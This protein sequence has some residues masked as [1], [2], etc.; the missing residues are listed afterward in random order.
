MRACA[1]NVCMQCVHTGVVKD[2]FSCHDSFG[3]ICDVVYET[4]SER[5]G[6]I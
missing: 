5:K 3:V 4:S 6:K 2:I 1:F